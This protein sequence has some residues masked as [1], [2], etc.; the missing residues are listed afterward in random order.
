M[1]SEAIIW[2]V[3][4]RSAAALPIWARFADA[5]DERGNALGNL[6]VTSYQIDPAGIEAMIGPRTKAI[7]V[8][9]LC[10]KDRS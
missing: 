3:E 5:W 1:K 9:N 8:P 7:L 6:D 2:T 4:N 10:G